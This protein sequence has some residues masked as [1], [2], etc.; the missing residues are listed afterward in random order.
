[1]EGVVEED[2]DR[3]ADVP[4]ARGVVPVDLAFGLHNYYFLLPG[5]GLV[6][7]FGVL[8]NHEVIILTNNKESRDECFFNVIKRVERR[9]FEMMLN[10]T[11]I[12]LFFNCTGNH[13]DSRRHEQP[14]DVGVP[15]SQL[16]GEILQI[17]KGRIQDE[18]GYRGIP[19]RI[20]QRSHSAHTPA[21]QPDGG[22]LFGLPEVVNNDFHIL[23]LVIPQRYILPL[24]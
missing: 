22:Y 4:G 14:R 18:P 13:L 9:Y 7:L 12:Y 21:P 3:V 24:G 17:A 16:L 6:K 10:E 20:H 19:I 2:G 5:V 23:P 11:N 15:G 1:M 8:W